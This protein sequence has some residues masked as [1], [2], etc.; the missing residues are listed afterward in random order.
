MKRIVFVFSILFSI[1]SCVKESSKE[2]TGFDE[3]KAKAEIKSAYS[4]WALASQTRDIPTM[5]R[6]SY[7]GGNFEGATAVCTETWNNGQI[8]YY[9]I[10]SV[11]VHYATEN[12]AEADGI[13]DMIQGPN[14]NNYN[15]KSRFASSAVFYDGKWLLNGLNAFHTDQLIEIY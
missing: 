7:S 3:E 9:L 13:I 10:S 1:V 15:Y 4:Q 2:K 12:E 5:Y 14:G 6:L 8:L 11:N